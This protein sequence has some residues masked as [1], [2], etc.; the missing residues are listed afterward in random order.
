MTVSELTLVA[1]PPF[2]RKSTLAR[3]INCR[4]DGSGSHGGDGGDGG[5]PESETNR[6][7]SPLPPSTV[8]PSLTQPLSNQPPLAID[9]SLYEVER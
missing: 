4:V 5:E 3:L 6:P 7:P 8:P 9:D 2:L 1:W